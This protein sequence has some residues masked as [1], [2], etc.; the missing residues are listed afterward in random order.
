ME[1]QPSIV[2][3][4][5]REYAI[6]LADLTLARNAMKHYPSILLYISTLTIRI[7]EELKAG[8]DPS[9]LIKLGFWYYR[10]KDDAEAL[11]KSTPHQ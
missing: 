8:R 1:K 7:D 3:E 6:I 10:L 9:S 5:I 4:V 2:D 11:I